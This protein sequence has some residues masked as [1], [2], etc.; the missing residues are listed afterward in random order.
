MEKQSRSRSDKSCRSCLIL[1]YS[2]C[3]SSKRGFSEEKSLTLT[4]QYMIIY[5]RQRYRYWLKFWTH[6]ALILLVVFTV[7][8]YLQYNQRK[9]GQF[10]ELID[11]DLL[12]LQELQRFCFLVHL[13]TR[14]SWWTI[15]ISQCPSS[16]VNISLKR[17]LLLNQKAKFILTSQICSSHKPLPKLLNG[18]APSNKMAARAKNRNIFKGYLL[19][20]HWPD[21]E[22]I[23]HECFYHCSLPKLLKQFCSTEQDCRQS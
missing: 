18:S 16:V 5:C 19:L 17:L 6:I 21:F 15:L 4:N 12:C 3:K 22:I 2:V 10:K 13:S 8:S 1:I 11:L 23:S 20:S 7:A 14:C 9:K